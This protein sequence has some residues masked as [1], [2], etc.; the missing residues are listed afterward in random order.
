MFPTAPVAIKEQCGGFSYLDTGSLYFVPVTRKSEL[1][2]LIA[3]FDLLGNGFGLRV[4][5]EI[6]TKQ[7]R[8]TVWT[9]VVGELTGEIETFENSFRTDMKDA[10][11]GKRLDGYLQLQTRIEMMETVL[12]GTASDLRKRLIEMQRKI[13][14][15]L[16]EG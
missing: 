15:K 5:E 9:T 11:L 6:S 10:D 4:K 8:S 1:A 3:L 7:V 13:K 2:K 14:S 12:Q 16:E